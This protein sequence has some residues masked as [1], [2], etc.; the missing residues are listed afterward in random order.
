MDQTGV[1]RATLRSEEE[2]TITVVKEKTQQLFQD[3][4]IA[5]SQDSTANE[6]MA[7]PI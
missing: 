3:A 1:I 6:A 7:F 2:Q 4:W 5:Q